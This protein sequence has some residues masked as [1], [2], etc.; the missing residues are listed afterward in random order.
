MHVNAFVVK[1]ISN[2]NVMYFISMVNNPNVFISIVINNNMYYK[3]R[4]NGLFRQIVIPTLKYLLLE[5]L[6]HTT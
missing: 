6:F 2:Q 3:T 1:I 5:L 4:D